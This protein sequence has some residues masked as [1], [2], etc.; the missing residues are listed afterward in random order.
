MAVKISAEAARKLF[1]ENDLEPLEE[2]PGTQKPWRSLC[3]RTG[4]EVAPAYGKVRDFGHRCVH[5]SRNQIDPL[6]ASDLMT[7]SGFKPLVEY[8]GANR[9]WKSEC[10]KCGKT[11][12]PS[13]TNVS[14][15]T[16]CKY[17]S[18]RAVEHVDAI[19]AM[20]QRGF[21]PLEDFPGATKLWKVRCRSCHR[22]FETYFHSLK[23]N[24]RC[25][26]CAGVE[27]DEA[28]TSQVLA[29]LKLTPLEKFPGA[30]Q[31]WKMRCLKCNRVVTPSWTHL[32]RKDRNVGGCAYCS[33][34]RV[35]MD[36][37]IELLVKKQLK[38]IG[39]FINGKTPWLCLCLNC[40]REVYPRIND[41]RRGQ[42]GCVYC[43]GLRI[44]QNKAIETAIKNGFTP[45]VAY[46]GANT[47][48]EC[49]C[50]V[51]GKTSKP[52]YTSMQ[53]GGSGCK[54]C[55]TGGFNFNDPAIVYLITHEVYLAHK[56][57]VAGAGNQN[58]RLKHHAKHGWKVYKQLEVGTGAEAFE[59]ERKVI[60]WLRYD[61][62]LLPFLSSEQ[63]PQ[64]GWTETVDGAEID[65][66][67][68]W[69]MVEVFRKNRK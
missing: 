42:S 36:E 29:S 3:L 62:N 39:S 12:S 64:A 1:L 63:M 31:P 17:C 65:L 4:K 43:A 18:G 53:Q 27:V 16:G 58:E 61:R 5:C 45:L 9:P 54:Y 55:A 20:R 52:R 57:G 44:D 40:K 13:Y 8:P 10:M 56:I 50:N 38:P 37:L 33:K 48:W 21:E 6:D 28:M 34:R 46:P 66:S 41:L 32:T 30:K 7:A 25:K 15:G 49:V 69:K 24:K 14:K 67:I 35:H 11:T 47:P 60:S 19:A 68:I 2:F 26:Y 51:C 59:I 22:E 23:T